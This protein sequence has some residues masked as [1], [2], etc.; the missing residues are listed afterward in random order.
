ML[1]VYQKWHHSACTTEPFEA[2]QS[3]ILPPTLKLKIG[4]TENPENEK[5]S[6]QTYRNQAS[7]TLYA[8]PYNET[9]SY[10][11]LQANI[12]EALK[13]NY[14]PD[15]GWKQGRKN[16]NCRLYHQPSLF[17]KPINVTS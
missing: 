17:G 10:T 3:L 1:G 6:P 11:K 8:C 13:G 12:K 2:N 5:Q 4:A 16:E 9:T 7:F 14:K 15:T